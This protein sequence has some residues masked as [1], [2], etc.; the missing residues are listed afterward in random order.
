MSENDFEEMEKFLLPLAFAEFNVKRS[1][2]IQTR[3]TWQVRA[4]IRC[5]YSVNTPILLQDITFITIAEYSI[6][7]HIRPK[8]IPNLLSRVD[9]HHILGVEIH[10]WLLH[11]QDNNRLP[12]TYERFTGKFIPN[13]KV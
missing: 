12:G 11:L 13:D 9:L 2:S 3:I 1:G 8:I 5:I 4:F 6:M 10:R 7:M